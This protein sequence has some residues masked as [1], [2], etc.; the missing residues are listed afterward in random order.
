MR[1]FLSLLFISLTAQLSA[2]TDFAEKYVPKW[3]RAI[4]YTIEVLEAMPEDYYSFKPVEEVRS[5]EE[6]A[7]HLVQNFKGLQ[8]FITGS[9]EC[10][11]DSLNL[12]DLSKKELIETFRIAGDFIKELAQ[13]Q[14]KKNIKKPVT[15]F[16]RKDV[17]IKKEGIFWLLKDHLAH[18]RGQMIIYLRINGIK[19][20]RYRGW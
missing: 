17:P 2:Q 11:I 1:I 14:T 4:E 16:F 9:K 18:H 3:E 7:T 12:E 15:D 20:P 8:R 10:A 6:Q 19:P 5:F 13:S